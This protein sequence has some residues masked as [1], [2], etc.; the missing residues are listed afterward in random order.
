MER[1]I[2]IDLGGTNIKAGVLD[3]SGNIIA[4]DSA[5]TEAQ[6]GADV[7]VENICKAARKVSKGARI[8]WKDIKAVGIGSP[9]PI[10]FQKG[11]ILTAPNLPGFVNF[12]LKML[13]VDKLKKPVTLENDANAAAF[14]EFWAGAAK[15]VRHMVMLTLGTGVGGG[16]II[17]G[18]VLHGAMGSAGELGHMIINYDGPRCACGN[19]GC[20][21]AYA[22]ATATVR[23]FADAVR[24]GR[25]SALAG[26][27]ER[28]EEITSKM[29]HEA[30]VA[31]DELS[32]RVIEDTG[33]YLGIGIV[34]ILH[35]INPA[36][37][38][39]SGGLINAGDML[40]RPLV[41]EVHSRAFKKVAEGSEIVFATLGEAAGFIGA[42]G[43]ALRSSGISVS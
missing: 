29:I 11:M 12:P 8:A 23:R 15:G 35:S 27:I 40:M 33:R 1:V 22:S 36:R 5:P 43:C 42:A 20:L 6:A 4:S 28:G 18:D 32:R 2:G 16:I 37:V 26:R 17:D 24:S 34:S 31:G 13:L 41:E 30:A 39:L 19:R 14:G 9:G 38:V 25:E 7:V 21:E 3:S 10:D